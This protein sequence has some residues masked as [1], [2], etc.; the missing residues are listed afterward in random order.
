MG[1]SYRIF[2]PI[3]SINTLTKFSFVQTEFDWWARQYFVE[4]EVVWKIGMLLINNR[5]SGA[6]MSSFV[7]VP[8]PSR[9]H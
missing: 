1:G 3:N 9:W 4:C 8:L 5:E 2:V 6:Q 7:V